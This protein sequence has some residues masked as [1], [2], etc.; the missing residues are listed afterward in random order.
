M[1]QHLID[2]HLVDALLVEVRDLIPEVDGTTLFNDYGKKNSEYAERARILNLLSDRL[3]LASALV[4]NELWAA[5]GEG[6]ALRPVKET[7]DA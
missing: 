6:D 4:R 2:L 7:D 1:N 3:D 5:R